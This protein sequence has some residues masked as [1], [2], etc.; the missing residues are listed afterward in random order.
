MYMYYVAPVRLSSKM[1]FSL[2]FE[3]GLVSIYSHPLVWLVYLYV[4]FPD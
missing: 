1:S 4:S 3:L 2:E